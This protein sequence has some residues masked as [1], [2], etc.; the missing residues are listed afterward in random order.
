MMGTN[1]VPSSPED[2]YVYSKQPFCIVMKHSGNEAGG[3]NLLWVCNHLRQSWVWNPGVLTPS[4]RYKKPRG[5]EV[6]LLGQPLGFPRDSETATDT[7]LHY[8]RSES[9]DHVSSRVDGWRHQG[10]IVIA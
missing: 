5:K 10:K 7:I 8:S 9:E 1:F 3:S 4:G 2:I 6:M